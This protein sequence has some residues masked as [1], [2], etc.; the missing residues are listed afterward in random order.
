MTVEIGRP[1]PLLQVFDMPTAV[2]F[3]RDVLGFELVTTS[4]PGPEFDWA[5]LRLGGGELMLNTMYERH[6]RP[7]TPDAVRTLAH[8]DTALFFGCRDLDGAWARFKALG[9]E[10]KQ[11][12]VRHYGMRQ[13][14]L[15]DP[16]GYEICLQWPAS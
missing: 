7:A 9:L 5:L 14:W 2:A 1:C 4:R 3:Y 10:V 15:H 11:P 6:E 13:L 12:V 16:D 8:G